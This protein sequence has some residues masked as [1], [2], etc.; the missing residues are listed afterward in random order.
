MKKPVPSLMMKSKNIK[1]KYESLTSLSDGVTC[2]FRTLERLSFNLGFYYYYAL[3]KSKANL[4]A[5][6]GVNI[7]EK[8]HFGCA[9]QSLSYLLLFMV[10][11]NEPVETL[12]AWIG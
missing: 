7:T 3:L 12:T 4:R 5:D 6:S 11:I 2:R 1:H 10:M 8:K 9:L